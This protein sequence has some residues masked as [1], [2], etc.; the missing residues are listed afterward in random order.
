MANGELQQ[1]GAR[2]ELNNLDQIIVTRLPQSPQGGTRHQEDMEISN[3]RHHEDDVA[4]DREYNEFQQL[5]KSI[6][7]TKKK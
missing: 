6:D 5:L 4:S 1:Y 3:V 7:L 2:L